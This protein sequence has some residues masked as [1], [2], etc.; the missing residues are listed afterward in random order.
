MD[1]KASSLYVEGCRLTRF[2]TLC[3]ATGVL[4]ISSEYILSGICID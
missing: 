2:M 4:N 3:F 1:N